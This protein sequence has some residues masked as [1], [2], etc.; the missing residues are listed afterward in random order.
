V[1]LKEQYFTISNIAAEALKM[2]YLLQTKNMRTRNWA[3]NINKVA[4]L[5][6]DM[7]NYF[8]DHRSHAFIP[9][10]EAI[11]KNVN[12]LIDHFYNLNRPVIFTRHLNTDE[13][14]G[15]MKNWW[16]D[17]IDP[18]SDRSEIDQ[19]VNVG[20]SEIIMKNQYDA[21]HDTKLELRLRETGSEQIVVCGV[22]TN[23]CCETTVRSAFV[24]GFNPI[25]SLDATA[26]YNKEMHMATFR[27]LAFGFSPP[28]LTSELLEML[29]Q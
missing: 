29:A 24:K 20:S 1:C 26:T 27:N 10:V 15:M 23:L 11:I 8:T 9:S 18:E 3:C 21:F 25:M 4:L 14:A 7:Q 2:K 28:V 22:M 12:V 13:D 19:R 17:L 6:T 16:N 5:V